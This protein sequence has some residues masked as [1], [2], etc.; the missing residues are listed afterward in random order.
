MVATDELISRG[1]YNARTAAGER[2][3]FDNGRIIPIPDGDSLRDGIKGHLVSALV[4]QLPE[5]IVAGNH[6]TFEVAPDRI[7]HPDVA[8]CLVPPPMVAGML[9]QGAPDLVIEIV[10]P[11]ETAVELRRKIRLYLENGA[12]AVWVVYPVSMDI[13]IHQP[14]RPTRL[15]PSDGVIEGEEPIP[16]FRISVAELFA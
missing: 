12:K 15:I 9:N 16:A 4:R 13:E 10:A 11:S 5:P 8:L 7:R 6:L 1:E 3:D 14:N 2:L